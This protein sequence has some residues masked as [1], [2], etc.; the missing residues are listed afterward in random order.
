MA[1]RKIRTLS[2]N[3]DHTVGRE[4]ACPRETGPR[5]QVCFAQLNVDT[6]RTAARRGVDRA[7]RSAHERRYF[8]GH[9]FHEP[10]H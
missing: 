8:V 4:R 10:K 3:G 6:G 2:S 7:C 9:C 5:G 1:K